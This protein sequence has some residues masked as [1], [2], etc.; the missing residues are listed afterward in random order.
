MTDPADPVN[1]YGL[2]A[3]TSPD[4][5]NDWQIDTLYAMAGL[6][7]LDEASVSAWFVV[8]GK[9]PPVLN[10]GSLPQCVAYS[11][12]GMK[13]YED[14]KDQGPF[15]FDEGLF[16]R[17]IGGNA[18]GAYV[19]TGMAQMLHAGYPVAG[20]DQASLH[21]IAAYYAVAKSQ[22]AIQ[23]AVQTFGIVSVLLNWQE[24][25]FH[26]VNG[27]LPAGRRYAGGHDLNVIGWDSRGARLRNSWGTAYGI[28]G[29]VYLS[30]PQLLAHLIEAWKTIDQIVKPPPAANYHA[31][32]AA[33]ATVQIASLK[34]SCISGW[35]RRTWGSKPSGAPC[36]APQVLKGCVSGQ[37]TVVYVTAGEFAG[38]R[39]R[40][41]SGVSVKKG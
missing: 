18:N 8:P 41:G 21:R 34:G 38:K 31:S 6:D 4:D 24:E 32:I 39:I 25:W 10:Q 28:G 35:T 37:A 19:R 11:Q 1:P 36:R 30:W 14:L 20:T 27:V 5:P 17:R 2:G 13:A 3:L 7:P 16:F 22:A 33:H 23:S 29:D 12:S 15:N 26:P 40:I 9:L